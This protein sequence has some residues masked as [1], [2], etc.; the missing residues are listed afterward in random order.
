[1]LAFSLS[2]PEI[3]QALILS[4][5]LAIAGIAL[6]AWIL[7]QAVAKSKTELQSK[8]KSEFQ[9]DPVLSELLR[10]YDSKQFEEKKT[11]LK[12]F[13]ESGK[14][15]KSENARAAYMLA[16]LCKKGGSLEELKQAIKLFQEAET[17][18]LLKDRA[19][20]QLVDCANKV[21]D[22]QRVRQELNELL[23]DSQI[24]SIKA[25]ARYAMAQ[26]Y[27]RT[28]EDEK[29]NA[30][31]N[32]L[33]KT[34]AD[35]QFALGARY[36]LGQA[37]LKQNEPE[38]ARKILLEYLQKSPDGRFSR[39]IIAQLE[40]LNYTPASASEAITLARSYYQQGALT[41]ALSAW[42]IAGEAADSDWYK[43]ANS[44]FRITK[45]AEAKEE[46]LDG[47]KKHPD[48]SLVPETAK[49]L[50][51][52]GSKDEAI[53]VWQTVLESCPKYNDLANYNLGIRTE[54]EERTAYLQEVLSKYPKSETAPDSAW[55]LAWQKIKAG[56]K[57]AALSDLKNYA[58]QYD[59]GRSGARIS[60]WLGKM[61]EE[62][63]NKD[64]A[65]LAYKNT[66]KKFGNNYYAWRAHA[67]LESLAG[68][69][70]RGWLSEP[71]KDLTLYKNIVENKSWSWPEPPQLVT[72]PQIARQGSETL[73]LLTELHQWDEC[74]EL[75][76]T[77]KL[78]DLKSLCLAKMS[79]ILEAINTAARDLQGAATAAPQW[80]LAYPLLH[81][82]IIL[83]EASAKKVD[84]FLAH[85]LIR[86]ESRYNIQAKSASNAL[87]LMQLMPATAMGV[88]KRLGVPI[89][90]HDEIHKP[91]NNLKLGIDYL[92]Y[93]LDRFDGNALLAVASYNGGP[94][95][96][97]SWA[98]K[99][100]LSDPD[101][102]VE[103]I[104]F[105]ET[106]DYVRKVFGSYWNYLSVYG[107]KKQS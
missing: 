72:Y 16:R 15:N 83:Q 56:D 48:S 80:Q 57:A 99:Y 51:R 43:I 87:G 25:Q 96:V 104:P 85:G 76:P 98:K 41:K 92:A 105:T 88:A 60:F 63:Q 107:P 90:S 9:S 34:A 54:N 58:L 17:E 26:S 49:M 36:Y 3:K 102:F 8:T 5:T 7:P 13:R 32:T 62:M 69:S 100:S 95:A 89:K 73:A 4:G 52:L 10:N 27:L 53:R 67:R 19:V 59:K 64:A 29:A 84:P 68:K 37:A 30:E 28:N 21:G 18:S 23:L 12:Q 45:S 47:I 22:E 75:I 86:E 14:G 70:D 71:T 81:N 101:Y 38:K 74:L 106:R 31:F 35:S 78:P 65:V 77:D 82:R 46:F 11:L 61:E 55:W 93:T 79:M 40:K 6:A 91:E 39:E 50:A 20:L 44:K 103:N 24:P 2:M 94:N 33:L 97:A 42:K 1:M 66:I